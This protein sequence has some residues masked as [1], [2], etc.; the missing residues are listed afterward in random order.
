MPSVKVQ[1]NFNIEL[2]FEIPEFHR[3]LFAF[4]LDILV[5]FFYFKLAIVLYDSLIR[6]GD[7]LDED[8]WYD[9]HW[10]SL[11]LFALPMITYHVFTEITMNGQTIGKKLMSIRVVNENG[12]RASISQLLIRWL[13]REI[14]FLFML[15]IGINYRQQGQALQAVMLTIMVSGFLLADLILMVT[16]QKGQRIGDILARTILI[17]TNTRSDINET[18]FQEVADNYVP[19]FPQVMRLSD[20]DLNAVKSILSTSVKKNDYNLAM[21]AA[22]KI[23]N[24]LN[25]E[26]SLSPYEFLEILLKDYNY[27]SVK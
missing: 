6:S 20:R 25:I 5:L 18:V 15:L 4:I 12:G 3:R 26:T 27:L 17:R 11:L 14:W 24:H 21:M 8:H 16:S 23:K 7:L 19:Q 10:I 2:E 13:L 1:T 22:D 9:M